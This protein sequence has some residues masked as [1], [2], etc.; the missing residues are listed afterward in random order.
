[1]F[2]VD[3]FT[4]ALS[5]F[6]KVLPDLMSAYPKLPTYLSFTMFTLIK[7]GAV[8]VQD[9]VFYEQQA[10]EKEDYFRVKAFFYLM[11]ELLELL[12]TEMG[13]KGVAQWW[14]R[15]KLDTKF[16]ELLEKRYS[17]MMYEAETRVKNQK[18]WDKVIKPL[19]EGDND[20]IDFILKS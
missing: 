13:S 10:T 3:S 8:K 9:L 7:L 15:N 1:M 19:L 4:G 6:F 16:K 2:S 20:K 14:L 18:V 12:Q 17:G 5:K 11:A